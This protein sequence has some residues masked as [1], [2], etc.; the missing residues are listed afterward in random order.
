M[1]NSTDRYSSVGAVTRVTWRT[2]PAFYARSAAVLSR[3][4][5]DPNGL[6]DDLYLAPL[7]LKVKRGGLECF[8]WLLRSSGLV[9]FSPLLKGGFMAWIILVVEC[10]LELLVGHQLHD[11]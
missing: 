6:P 11:L 8:H 7:V 9:Q 3:Q 4:Q 5:S 2:S 1:G 10:L